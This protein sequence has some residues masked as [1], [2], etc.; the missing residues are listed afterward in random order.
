MGKIN[1]F[2]SV[3]RLLMLLIM[4][5]IEMHLKGFNAVFMRYCN[6]YSHIKK[7]TRKFNDDESVINSIEQEF[8]LFDVVCTWYPRKANCIHK[9]LVGYKI[10]RQKYGIPVDMVVGVRKFP[11]EAHAWLVLKGKNIFN[12]IEED[13]NYKIIINSVNY[14]GG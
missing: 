1:K 11:F 9:T 5:D 7:L 6:K 13:G 4:F 3:I 8:L 12:D 14:L 2:I 10:I